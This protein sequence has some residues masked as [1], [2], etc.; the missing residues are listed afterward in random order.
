MINMERPRLGARASLG[1]AQWSGGRAP[2]NQL[3][4]E[5]DNKKSWNIQIQSRAP[6]ATHQSPVSP[7]PAGD[8]IV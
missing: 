1:P 5:Y 3:W 8:G 2:A 7:P 6:A 4:S